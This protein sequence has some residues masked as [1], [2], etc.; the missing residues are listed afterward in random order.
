MGKTKKKRSRVS[1]SDD[2]DEEIG[3][4]NINNDASDQNQNSLY[5]VLGVEKTASQ[6]EIKKAYHKLALRLHPDKNP[7]DE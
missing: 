6:Q 7:G 5:Q 4:D 1:V 3:S 2:D